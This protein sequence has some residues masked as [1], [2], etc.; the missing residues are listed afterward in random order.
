MQNGALNH[1]LKTQSGLRIY[2]LIAA[3]GRG[4]LFNI[5]AEL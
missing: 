1:A 3:Y 2:F 4:V 5:V